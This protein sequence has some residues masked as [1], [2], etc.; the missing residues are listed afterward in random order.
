MKHSILKV[1]LQDLQYLSETQYRSLLQ[2]KRKQLMRGHQPLAKQ[3][4]N[5]L[6]RR[7]WTKK[8][9]RKYKLVWRKIHDSETVSTPLAD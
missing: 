5:R 9:L 1:Q 3:T 4:C 8:V 7:R 2:V 6:N